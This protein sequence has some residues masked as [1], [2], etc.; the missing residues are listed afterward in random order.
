[1]KILPNGIAVLAEDSHVSKWVEET[2]LLCHDAMVRDRIVPL[3]KPG[4]WVVDGGAYIGD[5]TIAYAEAVGPT[6]RV[7]AFEV[8][9][10]ALECLR[11]NAKPYPQ[12]EVRAEAIGKQGKGECSLVS[13]FTNVGATR[14]MKDSPG[15]I[16]CCALDS[17]DFPRLDLLK[18]DVEGHEAFALEGA[19]GTI[20][21]H[22]PMI[23]LEMNRPLLQL[24][25]RD[26]PDIAWFLVQLGYS[27]VPVSGAYSDPQY[28][29]L[30]SP[31]P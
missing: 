4:D 25:G 22:R 9:P 19:V 18:L 29:L 12:I 11:H 3:L 8:N 26:Y 5:H 16:S 14:L 23:L 10:P 20:T 1:M 27:A 2:G 6:G 17:L 7:L 28:D 31:L 21:K 24:N 15:G 13:N 30:C